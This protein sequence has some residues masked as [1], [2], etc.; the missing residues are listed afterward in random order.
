MNTSFVSTKICEDRTMAEPRIPSD[1]LPSDPRFGCGPS[2]IR[3]EVVASLS[4]P[5]SVMG[6]SHRQPPV[7]HVVAAIREEL[8]TLY[9][10]PA[11]Y[12]V[13]LGNGGATLFWDM[14]TVSLVE[15]CAATGVYG[16]FTKKF[17]SVLQGAPFLADPA[18]FQAP[19]G[20][21]ALPQA[22]GEIDAYAWA[23]NETSTGVVAPIRR[24]DEIDENSLVLVDA[25]SA[26]GGVAADVAQTDAYYFS[27]QKNLSSDG[28][29]WLAI[30]SPAAIERSERL[31]TS[32][33]WVPQ[34]LDLSVA[35]KN[36]RADQ[37][38]NTPALATLVMLEAQCRWLL[39]KGGMT[40]AASRTASTSGILYRWA[41]DNPLTTPFVTDPA[42]RSPVVVTIDIDKSV[43]ATQLCARAR[44]NGILDIEPYRKLGRNQIRV[45]T[46]S[47]IEPGDIEALTAC[48]DWLLEH[49]D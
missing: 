6:T 14:A 26:V 12:E 23:H 44:E 24:P 39:D 42:L 45:A 1:L 33:R 19:P 40:W 2:R 41:E 29:L 9:D 47:S 25:T 20:E 36:S 10:L 34:M 3:R 30:L 28:G 21:L 18:V 27:P 46:F 31:T 49:R 48:L 5:G 15:K 11:E 4:E 8:S 22:L 17:S 37:T 16:E 43:D 7:R 13:A 35:V 38:L 32:A